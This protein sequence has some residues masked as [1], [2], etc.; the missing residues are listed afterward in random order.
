MSKSLSMC[1]IIFGV[2]F[3]MLSTSG[4][5]WSQEPTFEGKDV[6]YLKNGS[7][8]KGKLIHYWPGDSLTFAINGTSSSFTYRNSFIKKI[9][10]YTGASVYDSYQFKNNKWYTRTQISMLHSRPSKG[11]SISQ[12]IGYQYKHWM[13]GGIGAGLDNYPGEKG[14]NLYPVFAELRSFLVKKN[15]SPYIALRCG[16][17]FAK[18]ETSIG[19]SSAGGGFFVNPVFGYRLG[20]SSPF[21][22]IFCGVKFQKTDYSFENSWSRSQI[23]F[24]HR[25]YDLGV[26]MTF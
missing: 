22:D 3:L 15:V 17:A 5:L 18:T 19:Q 26:A 1:R 11:Y 10:M 13:T 8:F 14:Y 20:A 23:Q 7:I 21:I 6:L 2:A 25:R 24:Q 9:K 4:S 16:Y 12:S